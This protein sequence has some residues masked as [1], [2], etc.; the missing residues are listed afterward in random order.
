MEQKNLH[1]P[2]ATLKHCVVLAPEAELLDAS[3]IKKAIQIAFKLLLQVCVKE[4][5]TNG[6]SCR[7][8]TAAKGSHHSLATDRLPKAVRLE[9]YKFSTSSRSNGLIHQ[10]IL[11]TFQNCF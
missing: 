9:K 8:N 11:P 4:D 6:Y 5:T 10:T 7:R 3:R 1:T 2:N